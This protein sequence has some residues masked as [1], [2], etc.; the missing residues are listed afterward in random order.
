MK[1]HSSKGHVNSFNYRCRMESGGAWRTMQLLGHNGLKK[2]TI[3]IKFIEIS[4][5]C[6]ELRLTSWFLTNCFINTLSLI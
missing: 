1:R 6:A 4:L 2:S 3:V 5:L